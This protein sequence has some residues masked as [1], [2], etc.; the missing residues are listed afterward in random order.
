MG[1]FDRFKKN[2]SRAGNGAVNGHISY[3][4]RLTCK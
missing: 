2:T 4:Q 1:L 3:N